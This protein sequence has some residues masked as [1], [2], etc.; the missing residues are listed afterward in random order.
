MTQSL[1]LAW[2]NMWRNWRRTAIALVAI[3]LGVILLLFFDGLIKGSDQAIFG[4]AVRLYGGNLQV[5]APGFR[6]KAT[7]YP[8]LP[9][10]SADT[11]IEIVK[12][13][14]EVLAASERINTAGIVSNGGNTLRVAIT[15]L[16]PTVEAPL[17]I[18]A[19]NIVAGRF[20]L[21]DDR[22]AVVIGKAMAESLQVQVGDTVNLI[23]R[24]KNEAMRQHTMTIVGIYS[25]GMPEIE[26]GVVFM[27]LSDAQ[28]LYNLRDQAT[29]AV[30]FMQTVGNEDSL[31]ATL[32]GDLPSYEVD[33]WRSLRP[34]IQQTMQ[35]KLAATTFFGVVILLIAGIG[36]LNLML[37]A[38]FERTREMGVL[39]ALGMK[40]RQIMG[41]FMLEGALI[42]VVGALI[43]CTLG[44][45]L[46]AW[47][48]S[49]GIGFGDI[50][51]MGEI[52]ALMGDRIY[53]AISLGDLISR[54]VLVV[55]ITSL[56]SLF[57]AWQASRREP[58]TALHHV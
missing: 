27:A 55:V 17:S 47:V 10:A 35:T 16:N 58:A 13:Q 29:E 41:L 12:A 43:G 9:L 44:G 33:T 31:M 38:S 48:G 36:I 49:V 1:K 50:S 22:D 6:E 39:A 23:G 15:A 51:G 53:P 46:I 28:T 54:G 32:Q 14:P 42:G 7:R 11:V 34:E 45:L 26:R 20:L 19:E 3:I 56:A 18:Q 5:H 30:V 24:R 4:N 37:M 2:R 57:P 21:P 52:G 25:L 8:L 40:G